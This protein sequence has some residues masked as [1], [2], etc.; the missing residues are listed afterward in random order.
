[1]TED[2][3]KIVKNNV[4]GRGAVDQV[5]FSLSNLLPHYN[6]FIS[7]SANQDK[8]LKVLQWTLW[9]FSKI[10][11]KK[12]K[13]LYKVS[14]D[15]SFARYILRFY[16]L[17]SA[18]E[19]I[20]NKSWEDTSTGYL[21]EITGKLMAVAMAVYYPLEHLAYIRWTSP[22]L[23][24]GRISA[25]KLSSYSCRLWLVYI[26]AE[27]TQS[28][29]RLRS[30]Y[31]SHKKLLKDGSCDGGANKQNPDETLLK[32]QQ[33]IHSEWLQLSRSALFTLPCIDWS[34]PKWDT[35]PWLSDSFG[36][37]LMWMESLVSIYQAL[38][39][40]RLSLG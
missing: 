13:E 32:L 6:T 18:I 21:G 27:L 34:L 10:Y 1:M 37:G 20:Q 17:P 36:K 23:I 31:A 39:A 19:A 14:T 8:G 3:P 15:I 29:L 12:K 28:I 40:Y 30:L 24:P 7:S 9:F 16:G 2:G 26:L 35:E 33:S 4:T 22:E 25:N 38:R 5:C 11:S